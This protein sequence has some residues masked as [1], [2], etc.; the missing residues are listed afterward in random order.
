[1]NLLFINPLAKYEMYEAFKTLLSRC[2]LGSDRLLIRISSCS[3]SRFVKKKTSLAS[4]VLIINQILLT[5]L[6][7]IA[8]YWCSHTSSLNKIHTLTINY[9]YS[10]QD[11]K[12]ED[13]DPTYGGQFGRHVLEFQQS[14]LQL[15]NVFFGTER[16]LTPTEICWEMPLTHYSSEST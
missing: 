13:S 16:Y 11:R 9:I 1:M 12:L 15:V 14:T 5:L 7:Y 8:S 3:L 2:A 4:K 6:W 10:K